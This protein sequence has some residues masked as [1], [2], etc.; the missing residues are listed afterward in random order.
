MNPQF[1]YTGGSMGVLVLFFHPVLEKSR[2]HRR[3]VAEARHTPGVQ[4]RDQYELYPEFDVDVPAEQAALTEHDVLVFQHPL[5]WYSGPA[6]LKQ[7]LDL[8]L[9]HGWAY[10]RSGT[11]LDGKWVLHAVSSGGGTDAYGPRGMNRRPLSDYLL[12]FE[13]TARLCG[14]AWLPPFWVPGTHRLSDA[15]LDAQAG[16]YGGLLGRLA[17][18]PR[19]LEAWTK[20]PYANADVLRAHQP[21]AEP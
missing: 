18:A 10:G 6:L 12:P 14:M 4:V 5:Y 16:A 17:H 21:E 3:L 8:V 9:E 13:Q 1:V 2:V 15:E 11:A 19:D 7:W 20:L